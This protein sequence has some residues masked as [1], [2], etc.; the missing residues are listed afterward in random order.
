MLTLVQVRNAAT[1]STEAKS[2][3]A[4]YLAFDRLR[5][6]SRQYQKAFGGLAVIVLLSALFGRV[7]A[8]EAAV[9]GGLLIALPLVLAIV[10]LAHWH[11]L[12]R[13]LDIVRKEARGIKKS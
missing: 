5:T 1:Y 13:R 12:V 2:L 9:V 10:E 3:V 4:D 8:D 11:R 7:P 6:S